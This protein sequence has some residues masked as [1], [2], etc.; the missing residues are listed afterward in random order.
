MNPPP[1]RIHWRWL[2]CGSGWLVAVLLGLWLAPRAWQK[3]VLHWPGVQQ[4][5]WNQVLAG[6][7]QQLAIPWQDARPLVLFAGDS[8]VEF[9]NW[10]DLFAGQWA[11]RNCGL[12][13]AKINDVTSLVS[14]LGDRHPQAVIL[15]CGCNNMRQDTTADCLR[16]Y[17]TLLAAVRTRLNPKTIL[18]LS[19]MPVR[20]SAVDSA[21]HQFNAKVAQFN[22]A[23]AAYCGQQPQVTYLD[24]RPA[25][26]DD[27]G[28]LADDLTVD[29]LH[30]NPKGY[31]RL[32]QLIQAQLAIVLKSSSLSPMPGSA[33]FQ[34]C[35]PWLFKTHFN[36]KTEVGNE[37]EKTGREPMVA[38][39][40]TPCAPRLPPAGAN[41]SRS[42]LSNPLP[43]V[44]FLKFSIAA[45]VSSPGYALLLPKPH[46]LSRAARSLLAPGAHPA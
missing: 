34:T 4:A 9:G 39:R 43:I 36:P 16:D 8:Q 37:I 33:G 17:T 32:A 28:G 35:V 5:D 27:R 44:A 29:G 24:I 46:D 21:A 14:A 42:R 31:H 40:V 30:L 13:R 41:F 1:H 22:A 25:V 10:Y 45:S 23:L 2:L 26:M 20:E 11:V 38:G 15:L 18:V 6:R 3:L 7:Q 19:V 12:S